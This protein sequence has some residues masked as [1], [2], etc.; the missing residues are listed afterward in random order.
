MCRR[1]D[2]TLSLDV[3]RESALGPGHY[4]GQPQT[5]ELMETD[6]LYP[7]LADRSA[8][9]LWEEE[10]SLDIM[11][12]AEASAREVLSRHYPEYIDAAA[13]AAIRAKFP[14]RL[15]AEEMRAGNPRWV[16]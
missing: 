15:A 10:G 13:D 2:E 16:A 5:L 12:R 1:G 8:P 14:I 4:L 11:A 3:I 6:Y 7:D 9:G